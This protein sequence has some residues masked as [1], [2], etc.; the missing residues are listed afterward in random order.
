[1]GKYIKGIAM[2]LVALVCCTGCQAKKTDSMKSDTN[3]ESVGTIIK[4]ENQKMSVE[5]IVSKFLNTTLDDVKEKSSDYQEDSFTYESG[6]TYLSYTE[7]TREGLGPVFTYKNQKDMAGEQYETLQKH[8]THDHIHSVV[9]WGLRQVLTEEELPDCKKSDVLAICNP[10]AQVLGYDSEN[11]KANLYAITLDAIE[12]SYVK[13]GY[14]TY[15]PLK[16]LNNKRILSS[17]E[18]EKKQKNYPW[19]KEDEAIYIVYRPIIHG[20]DM[21]SA[22]CHLEMIY[23]PSYHSIVYVMGEVPWKV[24]KTTEKGGVITQEEAISYA[25][26]ILGIRSDSDV[27]VAKAELV[28]SQDYNQLR[29]DWTLNLCYEVDLKILNSAQY[30]DDLAYKSVLVN[31]YTG[32]ECVMWPGLAD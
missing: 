24:S 29:T 25:K 15:G 19:S 6:T 18:Y 1:M 10:Y 28:Y 11:S 9:D 30:K 26:S 7:K 14:K 13:W 22:Y 16:G 2:V 8:L 5:N 31:A 4:V 21:V 32:E 3:T 20:L 27:E 17:D 23:V 12:E